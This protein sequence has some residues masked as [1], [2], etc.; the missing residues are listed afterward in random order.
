MAVFARKI[1]RMVAL[2]AFPG[3]APKATQLRPARITAVG[4]GT[5]I[6][7]LVL[8]PPPNIVQAKRGRSASPTATSLVITLDQASVSGNALWVF[9]SA[10]DNAG[11]PVDITTV[12]ATGAAFAEHETLAMSGIAFQ[13]LSG[14][15]ATGIV[16]QATP[17]IT[18]NVGGLG[19]RIEAVVVELHRAN[20]AGLDASATGVSATQTGA[21]VTPVTEGLHIAGV[22]SDSPTFQPSGGWSELSP[23]PDLSS[24]VQHIH[25]LYRNATV[26]VQQTPGGTS[27]TSTAF[28]IIQLA[29]TKSPIETYTNVPRWSRS[30]PSTFGWVRT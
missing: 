22:Y 7:C 15:A 11:S 17:V 5:N 9:A 13:Q 27:Q 23:L 8:T 2:R 21:P 4:A 25:V 30:A 20:T 24:L 12:T 14:F 10:V 26:S 29:I 1:G 6:D 28:A 19:S 3:P 16:G 18:I